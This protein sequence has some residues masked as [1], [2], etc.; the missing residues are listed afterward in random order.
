MDTVMFK[1]MAFDEPPEFGGEDRLVGW[2]V[3]RSDQIDSLWGDD[4]LFFQHQRMD[5]DIMERPHYFDWLQFW[6]KGKF[7]ETPLADPAPPVKCP[8][9]YLFE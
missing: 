8:F 7:N 5:D 6:P 1:V 9:F 2:L 4:E 3:S